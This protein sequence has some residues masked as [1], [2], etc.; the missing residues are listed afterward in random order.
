MSNDIFTEQELQD[1]RTQFHLADRDG[2]D[3]I[4]AKELANILKRSGQVVTLGLVM[5]K[6]SETDSDDSGAIKFVEFLRVCS[7]CKNFI[8]P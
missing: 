4:S 5:K 2:N 8:K 7:A 6:V 3:S 1:L